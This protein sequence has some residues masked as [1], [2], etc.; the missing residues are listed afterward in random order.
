MC[1][2]AHMGVKISNVFV[3]D[4]HLS[5][6]NCVLFFNLNFSCKQTLLKSK[7]HTCIITEPAA[8]RFFVMFDSSL[9]Y[10]GN[11]HDSAV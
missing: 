11:C 1:L 3:E 7:S 9:F 5:D 2:T 8:V 4:V 6:H 10:N